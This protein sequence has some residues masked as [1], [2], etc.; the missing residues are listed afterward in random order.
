MVK[1]STCQARDA[2][3]IPGSG[4][5][6]GEENATHS[7]FL[8]WEIPRT[9]EP[10]G[11]QSMGSQRGRHDSVTEQQEKLIG[12]RGFLLCSQTQEGGVVLL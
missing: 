9:E 7:S 3:S 4:R 11:L 2:S 1:E 12:D 8:A 6:P 5:S 10:G